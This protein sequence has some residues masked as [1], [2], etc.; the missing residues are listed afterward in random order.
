M[1][2]FGGELTLND[3]L[4]QTNHTLCGQEMCRHLRRAIRAKR[5]EATEHCPNRAARLPCGWGGIHL[6]NAHDAR[7][8]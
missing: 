3:A 8:Q 2:S 1:D 7:C 4:T 5:R 6:K